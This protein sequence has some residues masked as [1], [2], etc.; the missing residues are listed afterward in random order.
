[1]LWASPPNLLLN[2]YAVVFGFRAFRNKLG[3]E[4]QSLYYSVDHKKGE[5]REIELTK[6]LVPHFM[7]PSALA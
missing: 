2:S 1:M 4:D 5:G 3:I 7:T 6:L